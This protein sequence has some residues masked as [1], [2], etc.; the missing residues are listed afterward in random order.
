V[1]S[2]SRRSRQA[3]IKESTWLPT[4]AAPF[5]MLFMMYLPDIEAL[6]LSGVMAGIKF[7]FSSTC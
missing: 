6:N 5:Y 7:L 1:Q 4:P 2:I 3:R